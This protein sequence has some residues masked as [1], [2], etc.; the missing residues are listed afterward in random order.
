M[1]ILNYTTSIEVEK[2]MG[3]ITGALARRGVVF[4]ANQKEIES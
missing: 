4:R 1:P 3:E 2:T